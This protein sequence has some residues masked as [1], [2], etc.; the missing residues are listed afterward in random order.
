M[1]KFLLLAM[2]LFAGHIVAQFNLEHRYDSNV[3]SRV[4]LEFSGEK[5]YVHNLGQ[6]RLDFFNADHTL[7]K[8]IDIP[9]PAQGFF[10]G[11]SH[12]S[13]N[14]IN[15]DEKV[16]V[17][18]SFFE[19]GV[20]GGTYNSRVIAEDGTVLLMVPNCNYLLI[21]QK[22]GLAPK[23]IANGYEK[24]IYSLPGLS[25]E[26]TLPTAGNIVRTVLENSGE[27]YYQFEP[28]NGQIKFYN[29][30]YSLWKTIAVPKPSDAMYE[31]ISF[32]SETS[33]NPDAALEI[34]QSYY[35]MAPGLVRTDRLFSENGNVLLALDDN[36]GL[37]LN[38]IDG[39][40]A[41]LMSHKAGVTV[42]GLPALN[43]EH[44][45]AGNLT[46]TVLDVSGEKYYQKNQNQLLIYNSDHSLWKTINLPTSVE[47]DQIHKISNITEHKFDQ[48]D[49]VEVVYTMEQSAFFDNPYR[50]SYVAKEN[51][52]LL[53]T[54]P[55]ASSLYL[56]EGNGWDKKLIAAFTSQD[57]GAGPVGYAGEVYDVEEMMSTTGFENQQSVLYPNPVRSLL[58]INAK[59]QTT[60]ITI[61]NVLGVQVKQ[62]NGS[63]LKQI[64][65]DGLAAGHYMVKLT[66]NNQNESIH[67]I[68][69]SN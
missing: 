33:I 65:I 61:Y 32:V 42:Y 63:D 45:Y 69:V 58:N 66:D 46:R 14:V 1:R 50:E 52:Q 6:N 57:P 44:F 21:D 68:I 28:A 36:L 47:M 20:V 41:K 31:S 49:Q 27:K 5:Y 3:V 35:R 8:S 26:Q 16:E 23:M 11:I 19:N 12:V 22:T 59:F 54:V 10:V 53:L 62:Q 30:D 29:P 56:S 55:N 15:N 64:N 34:A 40:P 43:V 17:V 25:L 2:L 7:W 24:N 67:K 38:K 4:K 18:Y 39:L 37:Q 60:Q 48:D 9:I 51:G 13:D